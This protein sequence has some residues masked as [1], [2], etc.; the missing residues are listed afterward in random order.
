MPLPEL[1][2]DGFLPPGVHA[3]SLRE[4]LARY[5]VGS[6]ARQRQGELLKLVVEA[7]KLYPTIKRV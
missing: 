5:A 2:N 6:P 3:A 7:A 1:A 4:V